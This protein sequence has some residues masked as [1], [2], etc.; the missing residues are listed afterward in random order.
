MADEAR[1][2]QARGEQ[3]QR[4]QARGE[5]NPGGWDRLGGTLATTLGAVT[6]VAGLTWVLLNLDG[7]GPALDVSVG[8]VLAI[9]GLILLMP[10]RLRL[11]RLGT[12]L[13][14]GVAAP[15]GTAAGL[16]A[17]SATT[18]GMYAYV[19]ERGFPFRWVGR[20][21]AADDPD[22]AR[23]L[24]ESASWQVDVVA[25]GVNLLVWAYVGLIVAAVA[26]PVFRR[27]GR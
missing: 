26:V 7:P 9:G 22:V 17:S 19:V 5:G 1:G 8:V 2:E 21:A 14:A 11:P 3:A 20:G 15:A 23:R 13:V 27:L 12:G 25:L 4:E 6:L 18:G 10:H 24:A 16:A